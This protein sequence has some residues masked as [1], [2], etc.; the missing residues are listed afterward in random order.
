MKIKI[1]YTEQQIAEQVDELAERVV[2]R[3]GHSFHV[4]CVLQ[5]AYMFTADLMRALDRRVAK[6]TLG[7]IQVQSYQGTES[8]ELK[9]VQDCGDLQGKSVVVVEDILD[10]GQTLRW[11][12]DHLRKKGAREVLNCV[13][14]DKFKAERCDR[15]YGFQCPDEFVV[16]Y[17]L[18]HNGRYR[19]L[20]HIGVLES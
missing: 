13:L 12:N 10:T 1:L 19:G 17:G 6:P 4:L 3:L 11:L 16:G 8:R 18:D 2:D 7:F 14:L 9:L 5:G 15:L 20:P